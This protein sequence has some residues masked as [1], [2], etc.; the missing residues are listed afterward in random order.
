MNKD[1]EILRLK[2]A[3]SYYGRHIMLCQLYSVGECSCGFREALGD[4]PEPEYVESRG[5]VPRYI[6]CAIP[7]FLCMAIVFILRSIGLFVRFL[8]E[9]VMSFGDSVMEWTRV[10]L[11]HDDV[12]CREA[13]SYSI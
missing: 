1:K 5:S 2:T 12:S 9:P 11:K 8:S 13:S 10:E 7:V 4:K 6:I 3:L